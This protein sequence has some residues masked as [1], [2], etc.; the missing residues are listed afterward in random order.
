MLYFSQQAADLC[1]GSSSAAKR[2]VLDSVHL[3]RTLGDVS[4]LTTKRKPFDLLAERLVLKDTTGA[5]T[6]T[7]DPL[8]HR[9]VL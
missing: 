6:R 4:L 8:L 1:R 2:D 5:W 9:Q 7:R 3:N